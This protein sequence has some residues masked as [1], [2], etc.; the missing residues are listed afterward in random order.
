MTLLKISRYDFEV[1]PNRKSLPHEIPPWVASGSVYFLTVCCRPRHENQL[2]DTEIAKTLVESLR[3][4]QQKR[5]CYIHLLVLMPDHLHMLASF[6]VESSMNRTI[7]K[8]KEFTAKRTSIRWQRDFF[9][10]RLRDDENFGLKANYMR[11]NP[12]RAGLVKKPFDWPYVW[13]SFD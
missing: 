12:F 11:Q 8:W 10:H 6:P 9:D 2:C 4:R 3:F 5:D 1:L 13:D 7:A